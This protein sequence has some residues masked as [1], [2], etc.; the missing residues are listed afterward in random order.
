M[1]RVL[2]DRDLYLN[3]CIFRSNGRA[4]KLNNTVGTK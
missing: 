2:Y 1:C 3:T 4:I